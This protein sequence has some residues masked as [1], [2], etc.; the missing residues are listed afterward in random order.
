MIE[1]RPQ[2]FDMLRQLVYSI[3][4]LDGGQLLAVNKNTGQAIYMMREPANGT[5]RLS[6][7]GTLSVRDGTLVSVELPAQCT[8]YTLIDSGGKIGVLRNGERE[9]ALHMSLS[10]AWPKKFTSASEKRTQPAPFAIL[11]LSNRG[12][13]Y[14]DPTG[15]SELTQAQAGDGRYPTTSGFAISVQRGK[16][17]G[18][19]V[20]LGDPTLDQSEDF[21]P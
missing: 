16:S 8:G 7:Q 13:L 9:P 14:A 19:R 2:M 6:R 1:K 21:M 11:D 3:A 5:Y 17:G 12:L 4:H 15:V 10:R 20:S 18:P